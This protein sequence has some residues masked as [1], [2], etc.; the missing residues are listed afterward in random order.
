MRAGPG[1]EGRAGR[2]ERGKLKGNIPRQDKAVRIADVRDH[3]YMA[4]D[5][6]I[7]HGR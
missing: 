1:I 7:R 6:D 2:S 3:G 4:K 5:L